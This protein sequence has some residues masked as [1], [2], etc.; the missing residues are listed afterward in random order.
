MIRQVNVAVTVT[1]RDGGDDVHVGTSRIECVDD[2]SHVVQEKIAGFVADEAAL[3]VRD[4][5][6]EARKERTQ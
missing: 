4:Q 3:R 6:A 1:L 2:G 5:L